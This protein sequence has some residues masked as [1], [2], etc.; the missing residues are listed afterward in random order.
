MA[1]L[2]YG[3]HSAWWQAP[4][5]LI[6]YCTKLPGIT[7]L[8]AIF[9]CILCHLFTLRNHRHYCLHIKYIMHLVCLHIKLFI[10][11][12]DRWRLKSSLSQPPYLFTCG[13]SKLS[14]M[15]VYI[16]RHF[17]HHVTAREQ[18]HPPLVY[19]T[20]LWCHRVFGVGAIPPCSLL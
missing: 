15:I 4:S 11:S 1:K 13:I 16:W 3:A 9:V 5:C 2:K 18:S 19:I 12:R 20:W 10:I 14:A 17:L 8:V 6:L 7:R